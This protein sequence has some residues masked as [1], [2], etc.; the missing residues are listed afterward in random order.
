MANAFTSGQGTVIDSP[1]YRSGPV[2]TV[3]QK[4]RDS[5]YGGDYYHLY[6]FDTGS[7]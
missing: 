1:L 6:S 5:S 4:A 3:L 2:A 7:S